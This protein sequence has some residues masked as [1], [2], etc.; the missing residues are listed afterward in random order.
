MLAG[1]LGFDAAAADIASWQNLASIEAGRKI[2]VATANGTVIG[3][4]VRAS[5]EAITV[6]DKKGEHAI[7]QADV[8]RVSLAKRTRGIWIGAIAGGAG[9][10][11]AGAALA[12]RLGNESGGDFARVKPAIVAGCAAAAALIGAGIG[13]LVRR[14]PTVYRK[15]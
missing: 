7:P 2:E 3:E 8:A 1:I 6:R 10:L 13:S 11:V 14:G 4:F 5:D 12:E 15:P 9:G